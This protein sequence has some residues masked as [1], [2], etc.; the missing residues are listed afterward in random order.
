MAAGRKARREPMFDV[1]PTRAE[2]RV[3]AKD[4]A[5]SDA[6][7]PRRV[8][9]DHEAPARK[10]RGR[11][12]GGGRSP[13]GRFI[14]W[15]LV[16]G[17]WAV[18]AAIGAFVWI[19]AHLPRDPVPGNPQAP[20]LDPDH[21]SRR[22]ACSRLAAKWAARTFRSRK[23]RRI[24]RRRSSRSRIAGSFPITA[25]TRSAW[26]ARSSPTSSIAACRRAAPPSRSSLPRTCS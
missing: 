17:L 11:R 3:S 7:P 24:C 4:R 9:R 21:R 1:L 19:G 2:L 5:G 25:S 8:R 18:I 12:G 15:G 26:R 20:A 16:L 14:Y 6:D 10:K 13:L 23:C 22:H